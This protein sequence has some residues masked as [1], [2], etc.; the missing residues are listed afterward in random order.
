MSEWAGTEA[1]RK[2]EILGRKRLTEAQI[3]EIE[4]R[5]VAGETILALCTAFDCVPETIKRQLKDR[6]WERP[7]NTYD[8]DRCSLTDYQ[9][10]YAEGFEAGRRA[11]CAT[12]RNGQSN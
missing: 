12:S 1:Q 11:A 5:W 7:L 4:E 3:I 2:A 6:G 8:R 9:K 10:G